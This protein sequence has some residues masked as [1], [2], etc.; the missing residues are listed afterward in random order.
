MKQVIITLPNEQ[1]DFFI[2]LVEKLGFDIEQEAI[3]PDSHKKI[4][5]E[6][7]SKSK[8]EDLVQWKSARKNLVFKNE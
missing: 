8:S 1:L 7:I 5:R 6:R 4:V 3:V 2:Q